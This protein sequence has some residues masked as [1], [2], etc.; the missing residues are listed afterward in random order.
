MV[1][2]EVCVIWIPITYRK[3]NA[4]ERKRLQTFSGYA[5]AV[6]TAMLHSLYT[7]KPVL[8]R[9]AVGRG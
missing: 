7:H 1:I 5:L 9:R 3:R 6:P 8:V 2:K 4:K